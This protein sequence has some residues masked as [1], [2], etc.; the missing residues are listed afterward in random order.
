MRA[1][2]ACAMAYMVGISNIVNQEVKFMD[3]PADK[4]EVMEKEVDDDP[5]WIRLVHFDDWGLLASE[6]DVITHLLTQ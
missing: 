6:I 4:I 3:E 2:R 5:F 1:F